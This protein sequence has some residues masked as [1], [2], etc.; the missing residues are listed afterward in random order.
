MALAASTGAR[1]CMRAAIVA[2]VVFSA[3]AL[4]GAVPAWAQAPPSSSPAEACTPG[5]IV[6]F[7]SDV[8]PGRGFLLDKD[9]FTTIEAPGALLR[10]KRRSVRFCQTAQES[11]IVAWWPAS[12]RIS[13]L[14]EALDHAPC[15]LTSLRYSGNNTEGDIHDSYA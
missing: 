8:T 12:A 13:A 14:V 4:V 9:V 2:A 1:H 6:D 7:C 10:S 3:L 15:P 5:R 11:V